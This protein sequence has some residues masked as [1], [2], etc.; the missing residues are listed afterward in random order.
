MFSVFSTFTLQKNIL[1]QFGG[2]PEKEHVN[3]HVLGHT[4]A[5]QDL[6][7]DEFFTFEH[8]KNISFSFS[9]LDVYPSYFDP[10]PDVFTS[11]Y[12]KF[13]RASFVFSRTGIRSK[14]CHETNCLHFWAKTCHET[15][16]LHFWSTFLKKCRKQF[17]PLEK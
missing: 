7:N 5:F 11:K 6:Q 10:F 15:N 12:S 2:Y 17:S 8:K 3:A 9:I 4:P 13:Q 14:T 1:G 16:C